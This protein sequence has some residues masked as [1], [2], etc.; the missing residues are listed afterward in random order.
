MKTFTTLFILLASITIN[1]QMKNI[2]P[3]YFYAIMYGQNNEVYISD[4]YELEIDTNS[5]Y[6]KLKDRYI[7]YQKFLLD[8]KIISNL[9]EIQ[10]GSERS[11]LTKEQAVNEFNLMIFQLEKQKFKPVVINY[12]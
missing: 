10:T 4:V 5:I 7:D 6:S 3:H 12:K 2:K 8:N 11:Y 1:A 9:K